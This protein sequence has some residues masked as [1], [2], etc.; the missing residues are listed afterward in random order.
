M[1]AGD[2][3]R[4]GSLLHTLGHACPRLK[5]EIPTLIEFLQQKMPSLR[6]LFALASVLLLSLVLAQTAA[7]AD[8]PRVLAI[9][10]SNDVN[11]VTED[12][13]TG[14]IDRANDEGFDAAVILLDTPGGLDSSMRN[15]IKS[16][17]DSKVP[18]I[19]YVSP[20]GSRA[21]SAGVFL[22][23]A[24]DVA[25]MAPFTNIGSSTPISTGGE[26]IPRDLKRKVVNDAAAYI[27]SLAE[28]HGRNADWAEDAVRVAS[29]LSAREALEMN[30]I[31]YIEPTLPAL[32][33]TIDGTTVQP[34]GVVLHTAG[35]EI[36][37]VEMSVW[38]RILDTIVDPNIIVLLLSLG[39]LGITVE[40]FNPGLIFPGTVGAISLIVGLF[41]LQVL[42]VSAAGV[43]LM[44]LAAAFFAAEPFVM[45][46]GALALAGAAC[47]VIGSLM[48]FDPAGPAYQVSLWVAIAIAGT[49]ALLMIF[50]VTKIVQ[51]RRRRPVTGKEELVGEV[52]VV[53]RALDPTGLVFIHGELWQARAEGGPVEVGALVQ[54]NRIDDGL[55]LEVSRAEAVA[56][57][58]A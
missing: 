49:F 13:L 26:D 50:A 25:A 41:G 35:A 34:K 33:D 42:P 54:V 27:R 51:A 52:G 11:P 36:E 56:P 48:L 43:L 23:M 16:M 4:L 7:A 1:S 3:L 12:Y 58:T 44:L 19:V 55:V 17:L 40:L 37:T 32:L 20:P 57:A 6:A 28:D 21:A 53:R 47:F 22:A 38:K 39:V 24:S 30:V 29:N 15:M 5:A 8:P 14:E 2:S 45:S 46:H 10:F 31:D 9:E 18:V